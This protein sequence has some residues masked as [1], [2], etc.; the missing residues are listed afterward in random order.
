M[1]KKYVRS[2]QT[3]RYTTSGKAEMADKPISVRLPIDLDL[4]VRAIPNRTEFLREA[5][6]KALQ[7][8]EELQ[9]GAIKSSW[10]SRRA[11][12]SS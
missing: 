10:W 1:S 2:S 9:S 8:R 11:I 4:K 6:A 12:A 3:G 7:E 5:I